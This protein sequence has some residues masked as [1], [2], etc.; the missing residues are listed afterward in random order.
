MAVVIDGT[1]GIT[2]PMFAFTGYTVASLPAAGTAGRRTHV[3]NALAPVFG[4]APVGGGS[5]SIPVF[6][7][8]LIWIVG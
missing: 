8:G 5:V 1:T 7:N 4:S 6:D 2:A 3:T